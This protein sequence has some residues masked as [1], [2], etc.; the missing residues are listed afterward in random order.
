MGIEIPGPQG[1][2]PFHE[3]QLVAK[4]REGEIVKKATESE[5]SGDEENGP[6]VDSGR[7]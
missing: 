5:Q 1:H 7:L 4:V 3:V 2:G 6:E